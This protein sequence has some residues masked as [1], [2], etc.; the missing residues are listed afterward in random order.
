MTLAAPKVTHLHRGRHSGLG[1]VDLGLRPA[2][3]GNLIQFLDQLCSE[4]GF[5][6]ASFAMLQPHSSSVK[7]YA[8]YPD[9]WKEHYISGRY[10]EIDPIL[11]RVSRNVAPVDW[12]RLE[13][14]LSFQAI[15]QP[16]HDFGITPMGLTI[17]VR[18]MF[19]ERSL[20]SVTR[21]CKPAEWERLASRQVSRL[22]LVAVHLHDTVARA[23]PADYPQKN[24][25][26][27][28]RET[29]IMQWIAAGK[30][31]QDIGDIL[32]ISP[33]TVEVHLRSAREKLGALTT[34]QA[35]GRAI[36]LDLIYPF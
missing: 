18:G 12:R 17:P 33:R 5:D 15:F 28:R 11:H 2:S 13:Q 9:A 14:D 24:P 21:N 32:G 30:Q 26:L 22:Q 31:Q 7:G 27:S 1:I 29:E 6:Y 8:N 35:V 25:S 19:G 10:Q 23:H 34:A 16:A 36:G 20:L 4:F 3:E